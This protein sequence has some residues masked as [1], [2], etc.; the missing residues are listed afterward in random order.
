ERAASGES[1]APLPGSL[2]KRLRAIVGKALAL[3]AE[4][5]Y[6]DAGELADELDAFL[7]AKPTS[8]DRSP[9]AR[10]S[11]W[12]RRN[13]QLTAAGIVLVGLAGVSAVGYVTLDHLRKERSALLEDIDRADRDKATFAAQAESQ[14]A[15]LETTEAEAT[16]KTKDLAELRSKLD[17]AKSDYAAL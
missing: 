6:L 2:P 3:R 11:L 13:P 15:T 10:A 8:F 17:E 12:S 14:R 16:K 5:R 4:D 7:V 9:V 1:P